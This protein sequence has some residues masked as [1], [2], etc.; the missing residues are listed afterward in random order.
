M[1]APS[2]SSLAPHTPEGRLYSLLAPER[3][4]MAME[5]YIND[6]LA[7]LIITSQGAGFFFVENKHKTLPR[8]PLPLISSA[9]ELLDGATVFTK[10]DLRMHAYHLVRI[11]EG[12]EWKTAFNTPTGHYECMFINSVYAIRPHRCPSSVPGSGDRRTP[13]HL[14]NKFVFVYLD[15]IL[16]F[17]KNKEEHIHHVQAVLQHLLENSLFVKAEKCEFHASSCLLSRL[18]CGTWEPADGSCQGVCHRIGSWGSW[19]SPN[20]TRGLS[21]ATALWWPLSLH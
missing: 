5:V 1:T 3:E 6:S 19:G 17:S 9:F 4:A 16:I 20:S 21:G 13:G 7:A 2:T 14:L 8:Y 18:H 11:R 12:D 15:D 10:L